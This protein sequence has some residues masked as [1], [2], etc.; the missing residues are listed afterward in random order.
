MLALP[1]PHAALQ[2]FVESL[3]LDVDAI[4]SV[5]F[6]KAITLSILGATSAS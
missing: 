5:C 3:L 6:L 2:G 4:A 1:E